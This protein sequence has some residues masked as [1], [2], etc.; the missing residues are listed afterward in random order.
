VYA[1][2]VNSV[3]GSLAAVQPLFAVVADAIVTV[4]FCSFSIFLALFA[5]WTSGA[6]L[7]VFMAISF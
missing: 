5:I 1:T 4:V 7:F 2:S 6:V 3:C